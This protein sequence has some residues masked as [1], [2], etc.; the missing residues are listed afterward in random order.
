[1]GDMGLLGITAPG[2]T[3][4]EMCSVDVFVDFYSQV[5]NCRSDAGLENIQMRELF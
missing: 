5:R 3:S 4:A 1:M 2:E